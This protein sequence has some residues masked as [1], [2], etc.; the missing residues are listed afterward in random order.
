MVLLSRTIA[1]YLIQIL[2]DSEG[3]DLDLDAKNYV[4]APT[5]NPL[6]PEAI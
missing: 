5:M 1:Q 4:L 6:F 2:Q 3:L